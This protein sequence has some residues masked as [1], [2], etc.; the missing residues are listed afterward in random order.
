MKISNKIKLSVMLLFSCIYLSCKDFL[1]IDPPAN[2]L[3]SA[4]VFSDSTYASQA[5]TGIYIYMNSEYGFGFG[6]GGLTLYPGLSA[7]E[8]LSSANNTTL[9]EFALNKVSPLNSANLSL[10]TRAYEYIYR[11]NACIE[12]VRGSENISKTAKVHLLG[13]AMFLRAFIY[14]NLA[15]LFEN[16]PLIL[17]TNY[18]LSSTVKNA[19][20]EE[21][22]KQI[23][24]DLV[25][26]KWG[27]KRSTHVTMRP[28]AYAASALLAKVF[29][30][31]GKYEA[32]LLESNEV[33]GSNV[34]H[35][36]EN[37]ADVFKTNN[38]E[39]IWKLL[40]VIPDR[41][42]AEGFDFIPANNQTVPKFK[43]KEGLYSSFENSDLRKSEWIGEILVNGAVYRYPYKYKNRTP[44]TGG[45]EDYVVL[46]LA[47]LYL[48]AAE[49]ALYLNDLS[50]ALDNL[51][52]VRL[53]AGLNKLN[54]VVKSEIMNNI[55]EE[56]RKELF[57]EW[58][59][60][61]FD[62]KRWGVTE[63][64]IGESNP[65]WSESAV[66]YPIPESELNAN[67]FLKQNLGYN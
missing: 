60:R 16:I 7:D 27:L 48:V 28:S 65:D 2:Q 22:Y 23:E 43:V 42:T 51:N 36:E 15:N 19:T 29:L 20:V 58:G 10:W 47:E 49:A 26:A 55:I 45:K 40:T 59:N 6:S 41:E 24:E 32:A 12:G 14:F 31:Q 35:L 1:T 63:L 61:W 13:E 9:E 57:C 5:L 67:P 62:L 8:I 25:F 54:T 3:V 53:R 50:K 18:V 30:F 64:I 21:V 46:R 38:R 52:I 33:I 34:F 11:A 56:R 44:G 17:S 39:T 66:R 4:T 37:L